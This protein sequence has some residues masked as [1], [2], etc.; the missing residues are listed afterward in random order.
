V[1]SS[2]RT[3]VRLG[4][5]VED[6]VAPAIWALLELGVERR[7]EVLAE[8][9]GRVVFRFTEEFSPLR[10]TFKART[11]VIEDGDL[12]KPDLVIEGAMPDI[13]NMLTVPTLG[14]RLGGVPNP[15][16]PRGREALSRIASGRVGMD[17]DTA[18]G[19]KLL[20]LLAV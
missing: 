11:V 1:S 12:R 13:V 2:R 10:I 17:G 16:K 5:L 3:K 15:M 20:Q 4:R 8:M 6:G 14:G 9:Q 19:L 18:F 7:P